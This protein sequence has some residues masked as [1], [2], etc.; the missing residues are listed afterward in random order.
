M[1][2]VSNAE[3]EGGSDVCRVV[4]FLVSC[5]QRGR[6]LGTHDS[7]YR[8][9]ADVRSNLGAGVD[10]RVLTSPSPSVYF[11]CGKEDEN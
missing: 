5:R 4:E 11:T 6:V 3:R 7:G 10:V 1:A 2:S 9:G 8:R